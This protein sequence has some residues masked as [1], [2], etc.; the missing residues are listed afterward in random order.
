MVRRVSPLEVR[1]APGE[2]VTAPAEDLDSVKGRPDL[3][4][5][6][7]IGRRSASLST[8]FQSPAAMQPHQDPSALM[9]RMSL[10]RL[11]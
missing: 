9:S 4:G 2:S 5:V 7:M 10:D 11:S 8:Q 3:G 1:G 6:P